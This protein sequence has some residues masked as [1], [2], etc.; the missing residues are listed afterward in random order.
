MEAM[1][2]TIGLAIENKS[3]ISFRY[4]NANSL[5]L[6][7]PYVLGINKEKHVL[8][9]NN[10]SGQSNVNNKLHVSIFHLSAIQELT[11]T[12]DYFEISGSLAPQILLCRATFGEILKSIS[13]KSYAKEPRK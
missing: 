6:A 10:L 9:A 11:I 12:E 8:L 13:L 2:E 3:V 4:K 7:A 5:T 1:T